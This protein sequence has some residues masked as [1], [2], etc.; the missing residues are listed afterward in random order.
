[1]GARR[2]FLNRALLDQRRSVYRGAIQPGC[3]QRW[4][5]F[6]VAAYGVAI[7]EQGVRVWKGHSWY[8]AYIIFIQKRISL[9]FDYVVI[10][11]TTY[12]LSEIYGCKLPYK[13]KLNASFHVHSMTYNI[14]SVNVGW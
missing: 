5:I 8:R 9:K 12:T 4:R 7:C 1:M 3:E 10:F 11:L 13:E 6:A 2:D 14:V